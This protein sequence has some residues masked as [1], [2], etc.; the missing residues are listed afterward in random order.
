MPSPP[1]IQS[2]VEKWSAEAVSLPCERRV[3]LVWAI[4]AEL[5]KKLAD[6]L[7]ALLQAHRDAE[8]FAE[9]DEGWEWFNNKILGVPKEDK[10]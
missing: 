8:W 4:E 3:R 2:L 1:P 5:K 9:Q 6:E 10:Q 7:S